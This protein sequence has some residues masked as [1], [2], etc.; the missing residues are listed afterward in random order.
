MKISKYIWIDEKVKWN[1]WQL[2]KLR[3]SNKCDINGYIICTGSKP[4]WLFEILDSRQ[5]K[6]Q[7]KSCYVVAIVHSK[8]EAIAQVTTLIDAIYNQKTQD[9][10]SLKT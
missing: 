9:Y 1:K 7:H 5:I 6:T 2:T 4:Q 8:K 10:E 3:L